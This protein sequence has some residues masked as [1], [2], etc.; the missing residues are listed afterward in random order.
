M[1]RFLFGLLLFSPHWINAQI[2]D[3]YCSKSLS[4]LAS[5]TQVTG[6]NVTHY[7]I[8]IDT[9]NFNL[10]SIRGH[11]ELKVISQQPA[12]GSF[13]LWLLGFNIDSIVSSGFQLIYNYNDTI[14]S[15]QTPVPV[16]NGDSITVTVYYNGQPA[17]DASGWGGFYFSGSYA[18]NLGVG[19]AAIPHNFGRA[20]YPCIDEFTSKST[21]DFYI[22][23]QSTSKAF[24]NGILQSEFLNPDGTK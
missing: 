18:F 19:F 15:I 14:I 5:K 2:H 21:Y 1:K 24:C 13:D 6:Y 7:N 17:Q 4:G 10:Q 11:T 12:M 22:R 16:I 3:S 8:Y 9:I 20:W 23:T